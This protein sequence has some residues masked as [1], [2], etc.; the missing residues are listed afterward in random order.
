MCFLCAED[1]LRMYQNVDNPTLP[2]EEELYFDDRTMEKVRMAL[3][4]SGMS[5]D[6]ATDVIHNLQNAGILFRERKI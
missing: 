5:Y 3:W 2:A 4:R 1:V 6:E